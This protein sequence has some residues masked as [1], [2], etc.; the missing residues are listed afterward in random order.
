M[1]VHATYQQENAG[2]RAK[3]HLSADYY[4]IDHLLEQQAG[5]P[6]RAHQQQTVGT[7]AKAHL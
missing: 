6:F 4:S 7:H 1:I 3:A 2:T 5:C